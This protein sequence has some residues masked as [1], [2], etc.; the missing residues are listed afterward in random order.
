MKV[1]AFSRATGGIGSCPAN[2]LT[3]TVTA[4]RVGRHALAIR[5]S[6]GEQPHRSPDARLRGS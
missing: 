1:T 6:N 3:L 4:D 2:V 5:Y